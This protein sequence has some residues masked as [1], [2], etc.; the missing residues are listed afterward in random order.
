MGRFQK[1]AQRVEET[2]TTEVIFPEPKQVD[3][4][5]VL[6][7]PMN[8]WGAS[9]NVQHVH[10]GIL[11][12]FQRNGYDRNGPAIGI[13]VEY[14]SEKGLQELL[15]H[16]RKF[17]QGNQLLPQLPQGLSGPLYGSLACAHLNLAFRAIKNG[18]HS[19]IGM[20]KDLMKRRP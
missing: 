4:N 3:P 20:L 17:S 16:N 11:R 7:S 10:L 1:L 6:V 15:A 18:T 19:P 5:L 9:P 12:S 14:K 2:L 13:C 8:R